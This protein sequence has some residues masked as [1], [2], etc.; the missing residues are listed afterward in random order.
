MSFLEDLLTGVR[1]K[2][3][4]ARR[5][6]L[7]SQP[8]VA[9]MRP[10]GIQ[11]AVPDMR[12]STALARNA[13]RETLGFVPQ[14]MM[15]QA[16]PSQFHPYS[17]NQLGPYLQAQGI[18]FGS[19]LPDV[20]R[21]MKS[22]HPAP[23][24]L[25]AMT[26][27]STADGAGGAARYPVAEARKAAYLDSPAIGLE[28]AG[29]PT[30]SAYMQDRSRTNMTGGYMQ[31]YQGSDPSLLDSLQLDTFIN[32]QQQQMMRLLHSSLFGEF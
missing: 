21:A 3:I 26:T 12:A 32:A 17:N 22:V 30:G 6:L 1:Q 25:P 15:Y 7:A 31:G 9:Q 29:V 4:D 5:E 27:A 19:S 24:P 18:G 28:P 2:R 16:G 8:H 20:Q 13:V 23:L 10:N 11:F 14:A